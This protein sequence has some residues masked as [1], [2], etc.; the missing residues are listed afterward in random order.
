MYSFARS[1]MVKFSISFSASAKLFSIA[2]AVCCSPQRGRMQGKCR[3]CSL[4]L[5][6]S[7][8]TNTMDHRHWTSTALAPRACHP[9]L[10][11]KPAPLQPMPAGCAG[12]RG[13]TGPPALPS[14]H[15]VRHGIYVRQCLVK[16]ADRLPLDVGFL[17]SWLGHG[18]MGPC[19]VAV[20]IARSRNA[21]GT[22]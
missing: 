18:V 9:L 17:R 8:Y 13:L 5:S 20:R 21:S 4:A 3:C 19:G 6:L 7:D 15:F 1:S 10:L 11:Q 12:P 2:C 16:G 14:L 22:C